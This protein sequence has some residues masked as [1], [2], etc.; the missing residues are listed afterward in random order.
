MAATKPEPPPG[1]VVLVHGVT[2]T[3][4]QRFFSDGLWHAAGAVNGIG[5]NTLNALNNNLGVIVLHDTTPHTT[6]ASA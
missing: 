6:A 4:Y 1:S 3:A 5:W 2:G